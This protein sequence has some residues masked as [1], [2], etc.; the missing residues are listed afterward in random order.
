[1]LGFELKKTTEKGTLH[2]DTPTLIVDNY[3]FCDTE[4][5]ETRIGV[6][7]NLQGVLVAL[8]KSC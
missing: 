7:Y 3:Q 5:S 1:M 4:A 2:S 6:G 8:T